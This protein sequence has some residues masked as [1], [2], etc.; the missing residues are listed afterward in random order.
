MNNKSRRFELHYVIIE[1][2]WK[3]IPILKNFSDDT[4]A[5][6]SYTVFAT[7]FT[8]MIYYIITF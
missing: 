6:I 4:K 3:N 8:Y 5:I 7:G 2:A 1:W